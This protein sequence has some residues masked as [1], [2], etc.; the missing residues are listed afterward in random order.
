MSDWN[1]L[2][3]LPCEAMLTQVFALPEAQQKR[4]NSWLKATWK[5]SFGALETD[6]WGN[7]RQLTA[8]EVAHWMRLSVAHAAVHPQPKPA[9]GAPIGTLGRQF[10]HGHGTLEP[11]PIEARA[12]LANAVVQRGPAHAQA[13]VDVH[14][15][16]KRALPQYPEVLLA[17]LTA[18]ALPLPPE[19]LL[20]RKWAQQLDAHWP[21]HA[22]PGMPARAAPVFAVEALQFN[23]A[24]NAALGTRIQ[25]V[26][27]A[28]TRDAATAVAQMQDLARMWHE[29]L[30]FKDAVFALPPCNGDF[31]A[32]L[33]AVLG[34][35]ALDAAT[36]FADVLQAL[37]RADSVDAQRRQVSMGQVLQP[38]NAMLAPHLGTLLNLIASGVG[39][40][41]EWAQT[42][43]RQLDQSGLLD[44]AAFLEASQMVFARKEKGL[45]RQQ[46]AWAQQRCGTAADPA[47]ATQHAA[48][49]HAMGE[50]LLCDDYA[51][52]R[53]AVQAIA[54]HWPVVA[55]D[56]RPALAAAL[57]GQLEDA[58]PA[59]DATLRAD[60]LATLGMQSLPLENERKAMHTPPSS[61]AHMT[62]AWPAA[63]PD[64]PPAAP[65]A[66]L[67]G[68]A[69]DP[70]GLARALANR[71]QFLGLGTLAFEQLI[72]LA[73]RVARDQGASAEPQVRDWLDAIGWGEATVAHWQLHS[74]LTVHGAMPGDA[75][76]RFNLGYNKAE[77]ALPTTAVMVMR[78]LELRA[79]V[80]AGLQG[81]RIPP[82][83]SRPSRTTGAIDASDLLA[84]LQAA[85]AVDADLPACMGPSDLLLALL[86]C[87]PA[88]AATLA[89]LRH[90]TR[91]E[92]TVAADFLA[93]GGS[94]QL[95][96][97]W[98]LLTS[99][100]KDRFDQ[101]W[102]NADAPELVAELQP[103]TLPTIADVPVSWGTHSAL[104][105]QSPYDWDLLERHLNGVLPHSAEALVTPLL[106]NFR[107]AGHDLDTRNGKGTVMQLP[108]LL[109]AGGRAG[110]GV[111]L[112]VLYSLTANDAAARLVGSDG[113]VT[114]I[115][116]QRC[117]LELASD[118]LHAGV[119]TGSIKPTRLA[120]GLARVLAAGHA[121]AVW[122]LLRAALAAALAKPKP[123][124]G[125]PDLLALATQLVATWHAPTQAEGPHAPWAAL[126]Q[127]AAQRGNSKL[128]VEARRLQAF[129]ALHPS[130]AS[131]VSSASAT[132]AATSA[133]AASPVSPAGPAPRTAQ[134]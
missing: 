11:A 131:T 14:T 69:A 97:Q 5:S 79:Q 22:Y 61:D 127:L 100:T 2:L 6:E 9:F 52:Q 7:T 15:L 42:L 39:T 117:D 83:L 66:P 64:L 92:A 124:P 103:I 25:P 3:A 99:T 107:K 46:L 56:A 115:E 41:A 93:A 21:S 4:L 53:A 1:T 17:I 129:I 59:I 71:Q 91:P 98:R 62:W 13:Y 106:W 120:A 70:E 67:A 88:D 55:A 119:N 68:E 116:Q 118:L 34:T 77:S 40:V 80:L 73:V 75:P 133:S 23:P 114:L 113:L 84:R 33:H 47:P 87:G 132:S 121:P 102:W 38:S 31:A 104:A 16:G 86:R 95:H 35:G 12:A 89:G 51:L 19:P 74:L 26:S 44:D 10:W 57:A 108:M 123:A 105:T 20:C 101:V 125:T 63:L 48:A 28:P 58:G 27:H 50:A 126:A 37:T 109:T 76:R 32:V 96:A 8:A 24:G 45:R 60:L 82:L 111:H 36:V 43:L 65:F 94:A 85:E 54:K 128:L 29:C 72:D 30:R 130:S 112:A 134:T 110:P 49:L 18:H 81:A 122:A 90:L 78:M